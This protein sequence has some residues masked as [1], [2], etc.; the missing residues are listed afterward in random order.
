MK[1]IIRISMILNLLFCL[2]QNA[3][4]QDLDSL[5]QQQR[6]SILIEVAKEVVL[7]YGPGYY[8]EYKRPVITRSQ[9][10]PLGEVNLTGDDANRIIYEVVFLYDDT[11]ELLDFDFAAKVAI[12][13]DTYKPIRVLFGNGF[14]KKTPEVDLRSGKTVDQVPYQQ[15]PEWMREYFKDIRSKEEDKEKAD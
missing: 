5:P 7:K 6:D 1:T 3:F 2:R 4:S 14:I 12:W 15:A 13:G 11:K 10:P 9:V 8:R